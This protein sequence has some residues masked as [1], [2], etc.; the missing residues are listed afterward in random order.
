MI[1]HPLLLEL[2]GSCWYESHEIQSLSVTLL[3]RHY[4][5]LLYKILCK[6]L[7]FNLAC[8]ILKRVFYLTNKPQFWPFRPY[9]L[10]RCTTLKWTA[11]CAL[12]PSLCNFFEDFWLENSSIDSIRHI[13]KLLIGT[14]NKMAME[15][16]AKHYE[17]QFFCSTLFLLPWIYCPT[18]RAAG[19]RYKGLQ[20]W[21]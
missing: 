10:N 12:L 15:C 5:R 20:L 4:I 14:F 2:Y 11:L 18:C 7:F 13:S 17:G 9:T 21:Q 1:A 8:R 6:T 19:R 3:T 16:Y